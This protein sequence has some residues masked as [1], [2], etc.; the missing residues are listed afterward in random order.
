VGKLERKR[1]LGMLE[2]EEM[3]KKEKD[4]EFWLLPPS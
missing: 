3:G 1:Q 4:T 2:E